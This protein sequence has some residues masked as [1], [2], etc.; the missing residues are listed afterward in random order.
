MKTC[1]ACL[2]VLRRR[3]S[4]LTDIQLRHGAQQGTRRPQKGMFVHMQR[5]ICTNMC[6]L[7]WFR[8]SQI[9]CGI[10]GP[11][12]TRQHIGMA[13]H[14]NTPHSCLLWLLV[15]VR[16]STEGCTAAEADPPWPLS[17]LQH[18]GHMCARRHQICVRCACCM[19]QC[20]GP[21]ISSPSAWPQ[22]TRTSGIAYT[23]SRGVAGVTDSGLCRA[24]CTASTME[25]RIPGPTY[26][27]GCVCMC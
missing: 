17:G 1:S 15:W 22:H 21:L 3:W 10:P 16:S 9:S 24:L 11:F 27:G 6:V 2:V 25:S 8:D 5:L 14:I 26:I 7:T 13:Y 23:I 12:C 18:L 4:L 19:H 20:M